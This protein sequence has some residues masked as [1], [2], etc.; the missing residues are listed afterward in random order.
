MLAGTLAITFT[1]VG[2]GW[3]RISYPTVMAS[4]SATLY[5][6]LVQPPTT[7]NYTGDGYSGIYIWGAQVEALAFPTSYIPTQASQVTR[8]AD[9]ASMTGTNF[10]SWYQQGSAGTFY[11]AGDYVQQTNSVGAQMAITDGTTNNR[12]QMVINSS[13]ANSMNVSIVSSG[14]ILVNTNV[15]ITASSKVKSSFSVNSTT[16]NIGQNG[17]TTTGSFTNP[18]PSGLNVLWIGQMPANPIWANAHISKI[19]Y[20]PAYCTSSQL[21]ALT[22]S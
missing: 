21:Q 5:I 7:S 19:S 3:T 15:S 8:A 20:Y 6:Y 11:L 10:S 22:G 12:F 1:S 4:A 17:N 13:A 2:N 18:L 16:V 9:N 14:S